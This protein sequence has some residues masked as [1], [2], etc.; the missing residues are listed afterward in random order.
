M[1]E[2]SVVWSSDTITYDSSKSQSQLSNMPIDTKSPYSSHVATKVG[3]L[4]RGGL[5]V[6]TDIN[7]SALNSP[8]YK[9][10]CLW[11]RDIKININ[12]NPTIFIASEY[13]KGSCM[14]NAV[15]QHELKH[16]Q[17]DRDIANKY[18]DQ[19]RSMASSVAQKIGIVG[20][21]STLESKL[22]HK[23]IVQYIETHMAMV[24][25]KMYAERRALQQNVDTLEEYERVQ[26]QCRN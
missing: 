11:V 15:M 2:I 17:V 5:E 6:T 20:P 25:D 14:Y 18:Q 22:T 9:Q 4:M 19:L 24:N 10:S 21:K 13:K 7:I 16:I 1:T 26:A 8:F 23:K 12:I 3:G